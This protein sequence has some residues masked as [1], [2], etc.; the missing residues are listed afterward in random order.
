MA[1]ARPCATAAQLAAEPRSAV[2]AAQELGPGRR[3]SLSG[4]AGAAA[5]ARRDSIWNRQMAIALVHGQKAIFGVTTARLTT[6]R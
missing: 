1:P 5:D 3:C 6:P 4:A 2:T